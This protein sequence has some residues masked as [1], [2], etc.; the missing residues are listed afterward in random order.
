MIAQP[1]PPAQTTSQDRDALLAI[2]FLPGM[3]FDW[4]PQTDVCQ[5]E[6]V[7]CEKGRVT[8]L[9]LSTDYQHPR[10]TA[11]PESFGNLTALTTL[12]LD[13]NHNSRVAP[14]WLPHVDS[15]NCANILA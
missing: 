6:R 2:Q 8:E 5:W 4:D 11:L 13:N 3:G 15:A 1:P 10:L 12:D 7:T 9:H 14:G